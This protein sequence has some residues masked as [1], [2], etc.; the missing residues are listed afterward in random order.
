MALY[1][2][3]MASFLVATDVNQTE[4]LYGPNTVATTQNLDQ[5]LVVK[6]IP[7]SSSASETTVD[8]TPL[9]TAK[10]A[11]ITSDYPFRLRL[12]GASETQFVINADNGTVTN[13]GAALPA[14]I[15]FHIP[16]NITAVR[17]QP[18][19]GAGATANI[20]IVLAGDPSSD[21]TG[22]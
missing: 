5:E 22:A 7:L 11:W 10:R 21:Y 20:T 17:V 12:N 13:V 15:A 9:T 14:R 3:A 2:E 19:S 6:R 8:I 18:V 4:V 16:F 1:V